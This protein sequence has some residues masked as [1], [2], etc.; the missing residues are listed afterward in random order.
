[1]PAHSSH[2]LYPLDVGCF[3]PLKKPHGAKTEHLVRAHITHISKEDF[4]PAFKTAFDATITKSNVI[5]GF[6][7]AGLVPMDPQTVISKL[8][9]KLVTPQSSRPSSREAQPWVSK[10]P[11]NPIEASSQSEYI[12]N[13]IARHQSS[14]PTSLYSA[15]DQ[16]AKGT[17]GIMHK[18]GLLEE[19]VTRLREANQ[20]L[21]QRRRA[22]KDVCAMED[23]FLYR[24]HRIRS[25]RKMWS[26]S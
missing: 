11:Q 7:G 26:G 6:K 19:E 13:R 2:L 17:H 22:K 4:F 14:S 3:G 20:I 5:G 1:M 9:V 18:M 12:K 23:I 25:L 16:F 24:M 10:T 21:S 8:D 15:I